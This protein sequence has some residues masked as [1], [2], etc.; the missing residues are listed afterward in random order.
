MRANPEINILSAQLMQAEGAKLNRAQRRAAKHN[1]ARPLRGLINKPSWLDVI[2]RCAPYSDEQIPGSYLQSTQEAA[3]RSIK[4]VHDAFDSLKAGSPPDTERDFD[5]ISHALG[6]SIIRAGQIAGEVIEDNIMLPPLIDANKAM[7]AVLARRR[8]W[9]KWELLAAE[10]E[11]LDYA[12]E[13]YKVIVRA[14]SPAQ[15]NE[16]MGLRIVALKGRFIE[17]LETT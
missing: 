8:K 13:I 14:S 16:A 7:R 2:Q 5:L 1:K 15:M 3:D 11:T 17:S 4:L 12:L 9:G 6:V 10:I